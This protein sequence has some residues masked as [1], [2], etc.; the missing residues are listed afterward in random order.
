MTVRRP[1]AGR[2][3]HAVAPR[4]RLSGPTTALLAGPVGHLEYLCTGD[5]DPSTVF[6]HG[7]G[8]TIETTRPFGSGVPGGSEYEN[9][10]KDLV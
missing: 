2:V 9:R 10:S 1:L 5:G 7:L 8:G 6:A 3:P 4:G